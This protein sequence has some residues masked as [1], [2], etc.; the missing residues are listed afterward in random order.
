MTG[1]R[2]LDG[3]DPAQRAAVIAPEGPL[4]IL[5][6]AGSGKTRV[7]TRRI[8]YRGVTGTADPRFVLALTFTRRAA[9]ELR[10]R[11]GQFG[12]RDLPTSGT[13]HGIAYAQLRHWWTATGRPEPTLADRKSR[14]LARILPSN[15]GARIGDIATEIEWA[16]ALGIRPEQYVEAAARHGRR[17]SLPGERL[18]EHYQAYEDAKRRKGLVDFDDLLEQCAEALEQDAEFAR[19]QRWRFR[20]LFVDEYQDVN[21]LQHRLLRAWLGERTDLCVVG[22]PN[23]AIYGWNGADAGFLTDFPTEFPGAAV[24]R[25]DRNHRS[26]PA[27][28]TTAAAVLRDLEPVVATRPAGPVPTITTATDDADEAVQITRA[29][30]MAHRPGRP[31]SDQ[32]VLVRTNAQT[33]LLE[34]T[35]R[36]ARIPYRVRGAA[37]F[38][39]R[40]GVADALRTARTTDGP[41]R[42][43]L[44]DLAAAVA[45]AR[46]ALPAADA[47]VPAA[48]EVVDRL[49]ALDALVRLG[50]DL[51]ATEPDAPTRAL[52]GWLAS[53]VRGED[54]DDRRF[55]AVDVVTFHASKGLEWKIVH[56][57]GLEEGYV[58]IAHAQTQVARDEERRLLYVALTRAEDELHLTWAANRT[59][60]TRTVGR[61]I[62]PW[63]P[64]IEQSLVSQARAAG[65][66]PPERRERHLAAARES[67]SVASSHAIAAHGGPI[68]PQATAEATTALRAWRRHQARAAGVPDAVVLPE[69]ALANLAR[70]R[71]TD[72]AG[73]AAVPGLGRLKAGRYAQELLAVLAAAQKGT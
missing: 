61:S 24:V 12:L 4:A 66:L 49:D 26:N 54:G 5:A 37:P 16:R 15:A 34:Q 11:L 48:E 52:P 58:P 38:L 50:N 23:Q 42:T 57:A 63:L 17:L 41:L 28:V 33:A 40:P 56:V 43:W 2:L 67:L 29:L 8:A 71:P 39:D 22:D 7:L 25:L 70:L 44:V 53:T 55:D 62:S 69:R 14:V 6:G 73:V 65:G 31:W 27:V 35:L 18:A 46:A 10:Q 60:G 13:F 59:F 21:P 72:E 3:L 64:P 20:H 1:D 47:P 51:L 19:G 45:D 9:G 30:R 68:T 36:R 32:A